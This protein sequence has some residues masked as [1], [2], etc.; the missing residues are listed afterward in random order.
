MTPI[1]TPTQL[2]SSMPGW[3]IAADL[4]PPELVNSRQLKLLRRW[5]AIGLVALLI[6]CAGGYVLAAR[7]HSS[8]TSALDQVQQHTLELQA[9][10][11]KYAAVTQI[12]GKVAEVEAEIATLM[13]GDVDLVTLLTQIRTSLPSTM[14]IAAESVTISVAGVASAASSSSGLDTSG[15][16]RI[17]NVTLSGI[18]ATLDDLATFVDRLRLLAGVVDVLPMTNTSTAT[19]SQYS[20]SLGLTSALISHRFDV[21]AGTK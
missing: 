14:T 20:L 18:G 10:V 6:A 19:A 2:W 12:Q 8:A 11:R 21:P 1:T 3:G 7:Q 15:L 13:A 9:N 5:L 4:T 16:A 17:G